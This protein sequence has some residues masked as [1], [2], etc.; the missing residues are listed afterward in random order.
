MYETYGIMMVAHDVLTP[1]LRTRKVAIPLRDGLYDYGAI[2]REEREL[3]LT[4]DTM[5]GL[6]RGEIREISYTLAKKNRITLGDE[7]DKYYVGQLYDPAIIER[8]GEAGV[9]FEITFVCEPFAYREAIDMP[10]IYGSNPVSYAGTAQTP[11]YIRLKNNGN[12]SVSNVQITL[13]KRR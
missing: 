9:R 12:N 7:Q 3:M 13:T 8:L 4:C 6:T 2:N 1:S 10:L 11:T 5:N